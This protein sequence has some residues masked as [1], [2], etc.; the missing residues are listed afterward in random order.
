MTSTTTNLNDV[1]VLDSEHVG[2]IRGAL[3]AATWPSRAP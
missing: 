1:A 3:G 2:D